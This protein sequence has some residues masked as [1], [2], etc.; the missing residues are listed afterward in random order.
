MIGVAIIGC[1][2]MGAKH[3][4]AWHERNDATILAVCDQQS[5]RAEKLSKVYGAKQFAQWQGAISQDNID[6]VSVCV[7]A[8]DHREVTVAAALAGRHILCE[9]PMALTL[10]QADDMTAAAKA[11]SVCLS[12]CHQY[13]SLS[14]FQTMKRLIDD[15]RLGGPLFIRLSE[16]REVR[17]KLAMHHLS[18]SGGPVHDMTGHLFDL[19]RFLT[20]S[21]AESVSAVGTVFGAGKERLSSV[22]E[23]GIDTAEIQVRFLGG[24]CLSIGINWGLP[25]GTPGH[26]QELIHGPLGAMYSTDEANPDRFLG[27]L[28][29]TVSV[30][31][32]EAGGTV[33]I[34]CEGD[35]DGPHTCIDALVEEIKTGKKSQFSASEG[36]AALRLILASLRAMET[37]QTVELS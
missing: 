6:V 28:S 35:E 20:G 18:I 32:K 24:H 25:E 13:R 5:E 37:G 7:P 36:R 29:D 19:A 23:F 10:E 34:G 31:I 33:R 11:N 21:E 1:G 4:A 26:C 12:V 2:D 9:K 3:A 30:T 17:P 27:D 8:C 15:G 14:R 16:M 22:P